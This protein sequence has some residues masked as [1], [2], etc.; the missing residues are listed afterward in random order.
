[1]DHH[2]TNIIQV[3]NDYMH[4][5]MEH[6]DDDQFEK[7]SNKFNGCNITK[8]KSCLGSYRQNAMS[9]CDQDLVDIV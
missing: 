3:L 4:V 2:N 1:M 5:I 6:D 7:L 9:K 8:C